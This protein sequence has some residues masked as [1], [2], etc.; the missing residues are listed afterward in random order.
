[1]QHPCAQHIDK[2]CHATAPHP[3]LSFPFPYS[4]H[5]CS[6]LPARQSHLHALADGPLVQDGAEALEH[7]AGVQGNGAT[8]RRYS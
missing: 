1:M 3:T 6:L 5:G 4:L 7:A 8:G 2:A